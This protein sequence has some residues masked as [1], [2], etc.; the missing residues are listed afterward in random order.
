MTSETN[1]QQMIIEI[2]EKLL[3]NLIQHGMNFLDD[4]PKLLA[5]LGRKL[6]RYQYFK[7]LIVAFPNAR[8]YHEK[9]KKSRDDVFFLVI[10]FAYLHLRSKGEDGKHFREL[11]TLI[12]EYDKLQEGAKYHQENSNLQTFLDS[13]FDEN[14]IEYS[15]STSLSDQQGSDNQDDRQ[16]SSKSFNVVEETNSSYQHQNLTVKNLMNAANKS[17][18]VETFHIVM[19]PTRQLAEDA[20]RIYTNLTSLMLEYGYDYML[21]NMDKSNEVRGLN[22]TLNALRI[23]GSQEKKSKGE[24]KLTDRRPIYRPRPV[25]TI[26]VSP[27]TPMNINTSRYQSQSSPSPNKTQFQRSQH[28]SDLKEAVKEILQE[29]VIE[30]LHDV[31]GNKKNYNSVNV[32]ILNLHI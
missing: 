23:L 29:E 24:R 5:V 14:D 3:N 6:K 9:L 26:S 32:E 18:N 20:C 2:M 21:E 28:E 13:T 7:R 8:E 11:K 1:R 4:H 17:V 10:K 22:E 31:Q 30:R 19:N 12:E 27:G 16:N 25:P 15:H